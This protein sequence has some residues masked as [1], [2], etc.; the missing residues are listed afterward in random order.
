MKTDKIIRLFF[1]VL[2]SLLLPACVT[3]SLIFHERTQA[4]ITLEAR[5]EL[6]QPVNLNLAYKRN[7]LAVVPSKNESGSPPRET[8]APSPSSSCAAC[9]CGEKHPAGDGCS[10]NCPCTDDPDEAVSLLSS[11]SMDFT[12]TG[13]TFLLGRNVIIHTHFATGE[14][15]KKLIRSQNSRA[16]EKLLKGK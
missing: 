5:P 16:I 1:L 4:G 14:A 15:A 13:G 8:P 6:S 7:V 9:D 11:F 10:R 12:K 2:T 3:D